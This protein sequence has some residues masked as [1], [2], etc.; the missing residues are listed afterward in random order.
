MA[1]LV[2][3][4]FSVKS[5]QSKSKQRSY[6]VYNI[7]IPSQ[8]SRPPR[9]SAKCCTVVPM[10]GQAEGSG[11]RLSFQT[12]RPVLALA[13]KFTTCYIFRN[14]GCGSE[15]RTST[16][17]LPRTAGLNRKHKPGVQKWRV[18]KCAEGDCKLKT[19]YD[20]MVNGFKKTKPG[21]LVQPSGQ[22]HPDTLAK[23]QMLTSPE[24]SAQDSTR[25]PGSFSR[26]LD[27]WERKVLSDQDLFTWNAMQIYSFLHR[28]NSCGLQPQRTLAVQILRHHVHVLANTPMWENSTRNRIELNCQEPAKKNK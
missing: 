16:S 25:R 5:A 3:R 2:P 24:P 13:A 4:T 10:E 28:N 21:S 20:K 19:I 17:A 26:G 1:Y 15:L 27:S 12:P 14:A 6:P 23:G 18:S 9:V 7:S 8:K 11:R 22:Q